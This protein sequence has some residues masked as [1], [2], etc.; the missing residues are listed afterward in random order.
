MRAV[1][2]AVTLLLAAPAAAAAAPSLQPL[3]SFSQ[4]VHVNGPD[5]DAAR[6]F[7]VERQGLVQLVVNGQR[8]ASPFLD[9][10]GLTA[11]G[12]SEQGLLSIAF[13]PDYATS[14]LFYVFLTASAALA[15]SGTAGEVVVLEGR[16]SP[17]DPN[18]ADG[19]YRR[20]VFSVP[21]TQGDN[22][23]GG[24]LAFGPDGLLYA[25][26]GDGGTQ[27]DPEGDAQ[28]PASLLG[29]ILRIDPRVPGAAPAVWAL[30]LRNPWRFSFDRV[31]GETII[32]DVGGGSEEEVS[33]APKGAGG[34]YGWSTCEGDVPTP[35]PVAG[36]IPPALSLSHVPDGYSGVI[37]GFVVRDPGLPT[38]QGRYVFGDLSKPTILSAAL[39]TDTTPRAEDA[40]PVSTPT[41]FGEDG[42]GRI[43]VATLGGPVARLR[44][45]A[46]TAC[47]TPVR[48]GGP[49]TPPPGGGSPGPD[50]AAPAVSARAA[51]RLRRGRLRLVVTSNEAATAT[52]RARRFRARRV[53]L[54]AGVER[55]V[56]LRATRRGLR[57]IRRA[58]R[59]GDR[60]RVRVRI[61]VR[62]AAGNLHVRRV[63]VRL[64]RR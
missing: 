41:S 56:R 48:P 59:A 25:G 46:S 27:G 60:P 50:T 63:T 54:E 23:N 55:V 40:L 17:N 7:V 36:A 38:L 64:K 43:Y 18:V 53:S 15:P 22:H 37:G 29:K 32:G 44:D 5:G 12:A 16:R 52:L 31:T 45:G 51:K 47:V 57:G 30:G 39:G 62:D 3:G 26:V 4:P 42:C 11:S 24:Q 14:G 6:V 1:L 35:C 13:A 19:D 20:V 2:A 61:A 10:T 21:H 49:G 58:L 8:L 9:V 33:I 34:N 28:N